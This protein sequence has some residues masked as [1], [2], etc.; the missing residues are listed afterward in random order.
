LKLHCYFQKSVTL[1][2][3]G[4]DEITSVEIADEDPAIVKKKKKLEAIASERLKK[5]GDGGKGNARAT[6][7]F[8]I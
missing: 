6:L 7:A 2:E 3:R 4:S 8:F 5:V 1:G